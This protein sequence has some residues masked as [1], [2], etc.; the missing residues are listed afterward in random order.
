MGSKRTCRPYVFF[1][2]CRLFKDKKVKSANLKSV[3]LL[4]LGSFIGLS[5]LVSSADAG[6]RV[7]EQK[8]ATPAEAEQKPVVLFKRTRTVTETPAA[9]ETQPACSNG[10]CSPV[11]SLVREA[12]Q[13][14]TAPTQR[15]TKT[16]TERRS[17]RGGGLF[18]RLL[19]RRSLGC[20]G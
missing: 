12:R 11:R 5:Y 9:V 18:S 19:Q 14:A 20:G 15:L 8:T 6:D 7:K 16:V 2:P 4:V 17:R 10:S 13:R 3:C 1:I